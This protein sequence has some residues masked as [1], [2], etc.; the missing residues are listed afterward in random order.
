[1][2]TF[3]AMTILILRHGPA[4]DKEAWA[5]AGKDDFDRPLTAEGKRKTKAAVKGLKKLVTSIQRIRTSPLRRALQTARILKDAFPEAKLTETDELRPKQP[6][7]RLLSSLKKESGGTVAL[8]GHEPHL[9]GLIG[10]LLG[11]TVRL[12]LKKA[13]VCLL[14]NDNGIVAM[15]ALV[16]P[17]ALR[18]LGR[19][20]C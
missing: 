20:K 16:P 2:L 5:R 10:S 13:G 12:G 18:W 7:S 6:S 14:I 19:R 4:G 15:H 1:M 3:S 17:A 8:V 11:A 9:S